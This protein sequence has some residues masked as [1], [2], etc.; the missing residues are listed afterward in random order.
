MKKSLSFG[1]SILMI[2]AVFSFIGCSQ[3]T[4]SPP[5][6]GTG[7]GKGIVRIATGTGGART[8]MPTAVFDHYEYWFSNDG[9]TAVQISPVA[10]L[11]ELDPGA[12]WTVTVKAFA[13]VAFDTLAAEGT[14]TAFAIIAGQDTGT[15]SVTLQPVVSKGTVT[16]TYTLT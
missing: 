9:A 13:G 1:V 15:I 8:L 3:L 16:F 4:D 2:L 14:S 12:N 6:P 7:L 10:D 5:D 11:F